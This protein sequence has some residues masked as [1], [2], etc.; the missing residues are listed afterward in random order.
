MRLPDRAVRLTETL[1][2]VTL[3]HALGLSSEGFS[4][5]IATGR[6]EPLDRALGLAHAGTTLDDAGSLG[7][8]GVLVHS[9]GLRTHVF[10]GPDPCPPRW[11]WLQTQLRNLTSCPAALAHGIAGLVP[12]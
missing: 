9:V 2:R 10:A 1:L 6:V 8:N 7:T 3:G 11:S 12:W 5:R 4:F